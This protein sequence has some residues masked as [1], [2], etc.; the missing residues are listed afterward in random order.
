MNGLANVPDGY[1]QFWDKVRNWWLGP[2]LFNGHDSFNDESL[3]DVVEGIARLSNPTE[4]KFSVESRWFY[5]AAGILEATDYGDSDPPIKLFMNRMVYFATKFTGAVTGTSVHFSYPQA[6]TETRYLFTDSVLAQDYPYR[7]APAEAEA[8]VNN[9]VSHG[10][11][12]MHYLD[13]WQ[14]F[15]SRVF[16]ERGCHG[17]E[18]HVPWLGEDDCA[19]TREIRD[20]FTIWRD[21]IQA[22][23][24]S[25]NKLRVELSVL[26]TKEAD[27]AAI[28][29]G[30]DEEIEEL[31]EAAAG[32]TEGNV[33][34]GK[35]AP[36][37]PPIN[38]K[39]VIIGIVAVLA[40]ILL[41]RN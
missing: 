33:P 34:S 37:A 17:D 2:G 19:S 18:L 4:E 22:G 29:G 8:W 39:A 20:I 9:V 1:K 38:M 31:R 5:H 36:P 11:E 30:D 6:D 23:L 10:N 15:F 24:D 12:F 3:A 25:F 35:P 26:L 41:L 32:V 27:Q 40:V 28:D 16:A 13:G 21:A 14:G 7:G